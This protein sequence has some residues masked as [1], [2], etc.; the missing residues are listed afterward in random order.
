MSVD[1][2]DVMARNWSMMIF[3]SEL[4][5]RAARIAQVEKAPAWCKHLRYGVEYNKDGVWYLQCFCEGYNPIRF[6]MFKSW[7]GDSIREPIYGRLID[8]PQYI[9]NEGLYKDIGDRPQ[10][11]KRSDLIGLKRKLDILRE[12]AQ[13]NAESGSDAASEG[14]E[15][16]RK[17]RLGKGKLGIARKCWL[18]LNSS[19]EQAQKLHQF[20]IAN[21]TTIDVD[22]MT[23]M[24]YSHLCELAPNAEGAE[25]SDI[26]GHIQG[27]HLL[28]PSLQIA[29]ILRSLLDLRDTI[30]DSIVI[31]DHGTKTVDCRNMN[32]Y[33]KVIAEIMQ[34]Y[35]SGEMSKMLFASEEKPNL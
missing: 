14:T 17:G 16:P 25:K 30:Q 23:E 19:N 26:K 1:P 18:C 7:I 6:T 15:T 27:G 31:D 20:M 2:E 9:S 24:I 10:Q 35:R 5:N 28:C 21:I 8:T 3:E 33:L 29:H 22:A 4:F 11:G 32:V 34:V 13:N 12:N